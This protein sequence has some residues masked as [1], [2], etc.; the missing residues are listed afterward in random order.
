MIFIQIKQQQ[1]LRGEP[2]CYTEGQ[3]RAEGPQNL[4]PPPC[5]RHRCLREAQCNC[6]KAM[7]PSNPLFSFNLLVSLAAH[8]PRRSSTKTSLGKGSKVRGTA[9]SSSLCSII[10]HSEPLSP[11]C[12]GRASGVLSRTLKG[13]DPTSP[14]HGVPCPPHPTHSI[15]WTRG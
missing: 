9:P 3:V 15:F 5:P 2:A 10:L 6:R 1:L 8:R 13:D 14:A 7:G 11:L 4:C 12:G